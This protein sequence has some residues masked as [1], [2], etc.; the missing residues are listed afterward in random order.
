M[1]FLVLYLIFLFTLVIYLLK[2]S[3]QSFIFFK[4]IQNSPSI[5]LKL[6]PLSSMQILGPFSHYLPLFLS[7]PFYL[8]PYHRYLPLFPYSQ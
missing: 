5:N 8:F 6:T 2:S 7:S 4:M 3:F 1:T